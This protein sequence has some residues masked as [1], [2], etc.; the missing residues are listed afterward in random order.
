MCADSYTC[1]LT[2]TLTL[3]PA[4]SVSCRVARI[5]SFG[6]RPGGAEWRVA[7]NKLCEIIRTVKLHSHGSVHYYFFFRV[8]FFS[9]SLCVCL[10]AVCLSLA[11]SSRVREGLRVR[12]RERRRSVHIVTD[13][14]PV[15]TQQ[16]A[17]LT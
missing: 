17:S 10:C 14:N 1:S 2:L 8:S 16:G 3:P 5:Y 12:G 11:P 13:R 6:E 15:Q 9:V 4:F 7:W